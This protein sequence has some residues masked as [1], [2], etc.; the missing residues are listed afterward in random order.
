M[1]YRDKAF[2]VLG[3]DDSPVARKLLEHA[4][5]P[6]EFKLIFAKTGREALDLFAEHRPGLVI[7][8]WLMP[9]L[10]GIEICQRIR[11]DFHDSST[12]IILLTGVTEKA[13]IVSG[14]HAGADE[15]LTK[16]FHAD[17]LLARVEV[18]R[19]IVL[20]H[21][22]L[23]E[24]NRLLEQLALTDGLTGLPNRRAVE[25]WA[26]RQ[27]KGAMRHSFPFWVIMTDLDTFKPINDTFGHEAGD[28]VLAK[29]AEILRV[30][31]R[32]C[33]IC[34][35]I[36]GDEFLIVITYSD[37]AGTRLAIE[38]IRE[39]V[40]KQKFTFGGKEVGVTASF[41]I[42]GFRRNEDTTFERFVA[43]ADAALYHA[44]RQGRNRIEMAPAAEVH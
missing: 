11:A 24:K 2:P 5:P 8:D 34:G 32:Q 43:R 7:T 39:Q 15:Y 6:D 20:L 13:K 1:N 10:T 9:D 37:E 42:A 23:E 29:F 19:R 38:R 25:E 21:R 41:G 22:E 27:L 12:Y 17:E 35:R 28:T 36:G 40:M 26:S 3:V 14:L 4:L 31:V 33:D 18:G 44:K 30:S 16:P